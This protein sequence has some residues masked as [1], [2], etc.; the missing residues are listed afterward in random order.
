MSDRKSIAVLTVLAFVIALMY[1]N[2]CLG[3]LSPSSVTI[4]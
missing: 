1:R 4:I 3:A 2:R